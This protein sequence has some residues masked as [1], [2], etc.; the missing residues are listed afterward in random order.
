M[1]ANQMLAASDRVCITP[2]LDGAWPD[3][4]IDLHA[5]VLDDVHARL[6]LIDTDGSGATLL[7]SLDVLNVGLP[8]LQRLESGLC[9]ATGLPPEA[10]LIMVSH[11][12]SAPIVG[13]IDDY[14]GLSPWWSAVCARVTTAAGALRSQ[15]QP[16]RLERG[17]GTCGFNVNRRLLGPE[18][19][20]MRPNLDAICDKRVPVIACRGEDGSLVGLCYSY[21]CHPTIL[22]GPQISGDYPGQTSLALEAEHDTVALFLPGTFGNVR[23]HL[24]DDGGAFRK[25]DAE[26]AAACARQLQEGVNEGLRGAAICTADAISARRVLHDLP[27]APLPTTG[28][29]DAILATQ[30]LDPAEL[31]AVNIHQQLGLRLWAQ[32]VESARRS[33]PA[34]MAFRFSSIAIGS[35]QLVGMSGEF[36]LEY[37]MRAQEIFGHETIALGYT[38]GCQS[39]VPTD[40]ALIEGGYEPGAWKRFQQLAPFAQGVEAAVGE[41]LLRLQAAT[42]DGAD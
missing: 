14:T 9:L 16:V 38:Q 24:V 39:Y 21:C 22:L 5:G 12:H 26:D 31:G 3:A 35:V 37:G 18:G 2:P 20:T 8:E 13:A 32:A 34:T 33:P 4:F 30:W 19:C 6:L 27:L 10:I 36:F 25:C 42:Q 17:T 29:I 1:E 15:L 28:E 41:G 7:I 11:S 40:R 23:P